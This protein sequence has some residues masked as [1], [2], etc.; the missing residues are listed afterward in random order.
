MLTC[1]HGGL[2]EEISSSLSAKIYPRPETI[3]KQQHCSQTT[4][5]GMLTVTWTSWENIWNRVEMLEGNLEQLGRFTKVHRPKIISC[6]V[7]SGVVPMQYAKIKALETTLVGSI[8]DVLAV[9]VP[10]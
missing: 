3:P 9:V 5:A 7:C 10:T 2:I 8:E 1:L 4:K 6:L